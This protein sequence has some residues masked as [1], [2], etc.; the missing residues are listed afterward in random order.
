MLHSFPCLATPARRVPE[1]TILPPDFVEPQP[2]TIRV[3]RS[4]NKFVLRAAS[5]TYPAAPSILGYT[6]T[7]APGCWQGVTLTLRP[8]GVSKPTRF[9]FVLT[10]NY[11]ECQ[12]DLSAAAALCRRSTGPSTRYRAEFLH[13]LLTPCVEPFCFT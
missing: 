2:I 9:G 7:L 10:P 12:S 13:M 3:L 8:K 4:R 11:K 5:C 6:P 1:A